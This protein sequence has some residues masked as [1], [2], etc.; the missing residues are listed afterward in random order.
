MYATGEGLLDP[1]VADGTILGD[2]LPKP[3]APPSVSFEDANGDGEPAEVLYAGAVSGSV[4][5]LLQ[6]NLRVPAWVRPGS[7]V[8]IYV[9]N[10]ELGVTVAVR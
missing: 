7:A 8:P 2:L 3:K 6:I 1:A 10:A 5:G 9:G 4:A